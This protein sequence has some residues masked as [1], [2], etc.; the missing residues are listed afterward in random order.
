ML[1]RHLHRNY[2]Y[3]LHKLESSLEDN[4]KC[5]QLSIIRLFIVTN[6]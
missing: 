2:L 5:K 1:K 3:E 6:V 4:D